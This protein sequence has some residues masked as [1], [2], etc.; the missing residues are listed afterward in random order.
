[1]RNASIKAYKKEHFPLNITAETAAGTT[2]QL[3]RPKEN[4][5]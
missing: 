5:I 1:M 4:N 2:V 3:N